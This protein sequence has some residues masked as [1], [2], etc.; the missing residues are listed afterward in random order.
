MGNQIYRGT[1]TSYVHTNLT[2]GTMYFYRLCAKDVAGNTSAGSVAVAIPEK[3][4]SFVSKD[5]LCNGNSPCFNNIHNGIASGSGPSKI[6]I[7]QG[8]YFENIMLDI[9]RLITLRG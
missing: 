5:G 9:D 8:I 1:G 4:D 3:P 7:A 6:K 2:N